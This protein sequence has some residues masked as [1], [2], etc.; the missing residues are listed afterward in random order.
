MKW[1][2]YEVW[3]EEQGLE[4]LVDTTKSLNEARELADA[5]I[6]NGAEYAIIYRETDDGNFEVVEEVLAE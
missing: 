4:E 1:E 5:A 6:D 3:A 2:L